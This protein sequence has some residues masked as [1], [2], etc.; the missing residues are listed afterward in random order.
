MKTPWLTSYLSEKIE[1]FPLRSS[2]RQGCLILLLFSIMLQV[3]AVA[4]RQEKKI[5][6]IQIKKVDIKLSLLTA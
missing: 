6:G 4:V 1:A 5:K 2:I 3:L